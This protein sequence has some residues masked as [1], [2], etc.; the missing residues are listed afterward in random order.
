MR[1]KRTLQ[2]YVLNDKIN[3]GFGNTSLERDIESTSNNIELI[4]K[5][6]K[7]LD[8]STLTEEERKIVGIMLEQGLL[9]VNTY[10]D[11][12]F[13]RNINFYEWVDMSSNL[14]PEIYKSIKK[15]YLNLQY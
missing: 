11:S 9:T 13:S 10:D 3:F 15:N 12:K 7:D 5:L 8:M 14:N 2:P 1:I 6:D 4:K